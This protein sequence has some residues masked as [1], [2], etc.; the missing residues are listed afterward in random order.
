MALDQ[1][2][3]HLE[4]KKFLREEGKK[5]EKKSP[6]KTCCVLKKRAD[7]LNLRKKGK[8][9]HT[10]YFI[11]NYYLS[12]KLEFKFGLTVTK[13]IGNAVKRNYLKRIIRHII[14]YNLNSI[15]KNINIEIIPKKQIKEKKYV[16]LEKDFVNTIKNLVI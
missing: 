9:V 5:A 3:H 7:F 10:E 13:K 6:P 14:K 16:E 11:I 2:C 12:S 15:P 8:T 4:V 1:E